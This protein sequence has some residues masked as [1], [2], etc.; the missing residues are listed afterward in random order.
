MTMTSFQLAHPK[1]LARRAGA[2]TLVELMVSVTVLVI[3]MLVV[4]NFVSL[5]QRTWV[6]S[7]SR[8]SQ[9][10]EARIAFDLLTRNL[11]QATLNTY[12]DNNF[13][14]LGEDAAGQSITKATSY[15]RQSE[16]QFVCG[17]TVGG[18]GLFAG[19]GTSQEYPGHGVFFQA[20]L[21]VT[22]LVAAATGA[23]N[24]E[25]MVN[26]MCG[27]GYFVAWGSDEEFRPTFLNT[28]KSVP[29]R[30]RLRLMEFSP[31]AEN[32]Q[33][34][35]PSLRP[36]ITHSKQWF[37]SA[38][39]SVVKSD[40]ETV[41]NHAFTR[42]VAENILALIISPQTNTFGNPAI[43]PTAIAPNYVYDSTLIT[44]P[45]AAAGGTAQGTRHLLPPLLKISMVALD[46]M[47]GEQLSFSDTLRQ[48]VIGKVGSLFTGA[49][50]LTQDLEG[51]PEEPGE[52]KTLLLQKKLN[53]RIFT[54]TIAL[55]QARWSL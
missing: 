28:I 9:F 23:A 24:T 2:F 31:T 39:T 10:R 38:L 12:W 34:Y 33:I 1:R 17:P 13:D 19:G 25:N 44:N 35:L 26:L 5:V 21:G 7:N 14:N 18:G 40:S 27:R 42:P 50:N 11:S 6:R 3:L 20:P 37:A 30:F 15:I 36:I 54:T 43:N 16:F 47:A 55:K 53:F 22:S 8:V 4:A 51:T 32:N 45:G 52:L 29:P 49:S 41:A 46:Q 48:E